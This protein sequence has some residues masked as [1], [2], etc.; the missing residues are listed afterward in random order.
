MTRSILAALLAAGV[1]ALAT[2][3]VCVGAARAQERPEV[4]PQL[5][6][7]QGVFSLAFAP[8]GNTLASGSA[9]NTVKFWD[10]ASRREIRSLGPGLPAISLAFSPDG[11]VLAIGLLNQKIKLIDAATGGELRT[12]TGHAGPV[13]SVTF[14]PDGHFLA[15]A[16]D[17][18]TIKVWDVARGAEVVTLGG[19]SR[20]VVSVAFSPDGRL[21]AANSADHVIRLWDLTA[22]RE[23]RSL[24]VNSVGAI[25]FSPDGRMLAAGSINNTVKFWDVAS[26]R[27]LR[28]MRGHSD[29]VALVAF[30]PDGRILASSSYDK[31][32]K[33]W[34]VASGREVGTLSG[35]FSLP[36]MLWA[37]S[38]AFSPT[39]HIL[40][41]GIGDGPIRLWDTATGRELPPLGGRSV[42]TTSALYS[43][44]GRLVAFGSFDGSIKIWDAASGR[45]LRALSGHAG[46]V[47]SI[48]F[49]PDG[50]VLA[51]GSA[52]HTA[53]LWDVAS[54]REL[55]TLS[56]HAEQ[57]MSVTFSPDGRILASGSGDRTIK[58]WDAANGNGLRTLTGHS[59]WINSVAFSPDGRILASGSGLLG[60]DG[61][62][63]NNAIKLWDVAS[64]SELR[65]LIGHGAWVTAVAFSR[66]GKL[67]GSAS[68]DRTVKLWDAASG[69]EQRTLGGFVD[70]VSSLAFSPDGRVVA[71]GAH[72]STVKLWDAATGGDI[73]TLA[74]HGDLIASVAFA[75]DGRRLVTA[76]WSSA[77]R[78]WNLASGAE[79]ASLVA[80]TDGSSLAI[81]PDG[82]YDASSETA[83]ENLNVR[84]GTR[85]F[86]IA[87][88]R[89]KFYRPDVLKLSLAGRSL[90]EFG[91]ASIDSVKVAPIVELADVPQTV[92]QSKL[93][94]NLRLTDGGGGI[95]QVR[96][97][98]NGSAV[99][100]D[101]APA[102][103]SPG[104]G[105]RTYSV[106]LADGPN[107]LQA[108]AYNADN[109]MHSDSAIA[110][111]SA[112]LPP[113]N[114]SNLHAVVVG[115]REFTNSKLNLTYP[116]EDAQLFAK[117]LTKYSASL[118]QKIDIKL[119]VTP[120]ET[121]RDALIQS[122]KDMQSTVGP[123]D[124]F[125]FYV[126]SHGS[127]DNGEYF[128]ITSNV[129]SV[130]TEHLKTDAISK[131]ELTALVANVPATKK[132]LVI[133]TSH[134]ETLGNALLTR[135]LDEPTALKILS[136]AVGTTVLAAS[137]STQEALEGY[138]G[139]G[140]FSFVVADG[141][142]GKGDVDKDGFVSTFGLA[143][144]VDIEVP[145]LAQREFNHDQFPVI[146]TSGQ[147]FPLTKVR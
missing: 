29:L 16:S 14:S 40:V 39:G 35:G 64:G 42:G 120:A 141:L 49:S 112:N 57:V 1:A 53:K 56:G 118:F 65:T 139:H 102:P 126:A 9:D 5:G 116:V 70:R 62:N 72:D 121:T 134:A 83:E 74:S 15:S 76:S 93:T 69:R 124:L 25:A 38:M 80:F 109:T 51:S 24:K 3:W 43:P 88:Y 105:M 71:A 91:L 97:F 145:K 17:D 60:G 92:S 133:D 108:E 78:I 144:Y 113:A 19:F 125:V 89:D 122:I 147:Q 6:H 34:E 58:L 13:G 136:R 18:R 87:S 135:G 23:L 111:I 138:Q 26:G 31:T 8:D 110:K 117:T 32:V 61:V 22:G 12:F 55:R 137:T 41:L 95:G 30:S 50:H 106:Q 75:P 84:V 44:D 10:V 63:A 130:S 86:A 132:L 79:I 20:P 33:L 2:Q 54:G 77:V 123:D 142:A 140:L 27:E 85:V 11:R 52:D 82:Y 119:L 81:T 90:R 28:A 100:Q 47:N 36:S 143:H 127:T 48:A 129:G 67:V 21:L 99:V 128:L 103:R 101:N 131:E 94:V 37:S 73:R 115:I 104:G 68:G 45:E 46:I 146:E 98:V 59:T 96:L 4:F 114:R 66:D 107:V 7:S